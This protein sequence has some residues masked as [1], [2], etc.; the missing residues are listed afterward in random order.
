MSSAHDGNQLRTN[1]PTNAGQLTF[2]GKLLARVDSIR[3]HTGGSRRQFITFTL[4]LAVAGSLWARPAG[5]LLWHRLRIITGMPRMAVAVDE[6]ETMA[7]LTPDTPASLDAGRAVRLDGAL[8]RDPFVPA[9]SAV[10]HV[11]QTNAVGQSNATPAGGSTLEPPVVF[12]LP[13]VRLSGTARG[14]GTAILDGIVRQVGER[15]DISGAVM[16]LREVRSGAVVVE[17]DGAGPRLLL[18]SGEWRELE[19]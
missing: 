11:A 8:R 5:L 12:T 6:A 16:E 17:V 15:F 19:N 10:I 1:L 3:A 9:A 7:A 13:Q 2:R 18:L 4:L 14:L